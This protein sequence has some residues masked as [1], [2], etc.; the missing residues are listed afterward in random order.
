MSSK[1]YR[2]LARE[3]INKE[4]WWDLLSRFIDVL[5]INLFV[6]DNQGLIILPPEEGRYG[7]R[8]LTDHSLKFDL[9]DDSVH[10]DAQ[11]ERNGD[12]LEAYNRF[13]LHSF[14]IPINTDGQIIAYMVVGPVVLNKRLSGSDYEAMAVKFGCDKGDLLNE[15]GGIRVVSNIMINSILDLLSE[16]VRDN[17]ELSLRKKELSEIKSDMGGGIKE[18]TEKANEIYST[19]YFDELLVTLLDV[20]LKMTKAECGSIMVKDVRQNELTIKA[21][22]GLDSEKVQNARIKLGEGIAGIAAQVNESF[23]IHGTEGDNRIKPFLKRPEIKEALVMPLSKHEDVFGVLSL[24]TERDG[25]KIDA[26]LENLQ[27]L[28]KLMSVAFLLE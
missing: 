24:H 18:F 6:V 8:L 2:Q 25:G 12:F 10:V 13:D 9:V 21:S 1:D 14:A 11:F 23:I 5:R 20:A 16:I 7:G 27:Y 17:I 3:V 28:S 4:K 15:L 19:V 26:N 22:R